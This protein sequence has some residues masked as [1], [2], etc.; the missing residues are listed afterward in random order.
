MRW[1]VVADAERHLMAFEYVA[2][3]SGIHSQFRA[4]HG[5][6]PLAKPLTHGA[7]LPLGETDPMRQG[8]IGFEVGC[9]GAREGLVNDVQ[10]RLIVEAKG[11]VVEVGGTNRGKQ[12][13]DDHHL[14]VIHRGGV[15]RDDRS[16]AQQGTPIGPRSTAN[17]ITV[18]VLA[19]ND[20]AQLDPSLE[21]INQGA[22][23]QGVR[24]EIGR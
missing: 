15:L 11:T 2:N 8:Q 16:S 21:C 9:L 1:V 5:C 19:R 7:I 3:R 17:G 10:R 13:I 23:G 24:H 6:D 18:D 4:Y 20:D 22:R 12:T 14:A